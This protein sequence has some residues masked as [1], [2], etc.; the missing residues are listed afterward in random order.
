MD[1]P[2]IKIPLPFAANAAAP[3]RIA[4]PTTSQIGIVN[5]AASFNDGFPPL[6]FVSMSSG[7]VGPFGRDFNGLMYQI[8]AGLQ[9]EQAGYAATFDA[10]FSAAIGGYPA[11]AVL[12]S[13]STA[14][15]FY[16]N[17]VNSNTV[18]P[19]GA[20]T[21][22][23]VL[24]MATAFPISVPNGGTGETI[25]SPGEILLGNGI[26]PV[27]STPYLT[28][29]RGGT[30]ALSFNA[31]E[32]LIGNGV[33]AVNS[34]PVLNV[35]RGGTGNN[36]LTQ[37][38]VLAGSG[39]SGVAQIGVSASVG[40]PLCSNGASAHSSFQL[41]NLT[42]SVTGK[43]NLSNSPNS[44]LVV[45]TAAPGMYT[46]AVP[47][48]T[49]WI[50]GMCIGGGGGGAGGN[51][52]HS[53]GGGGAGGIQG[54][55]TMGWFAVMPGDLIN[56]TVGAGGTAGLGGSV[57]STN[58]GNGSTSSIGAVMSATGGAG[59]RSTGG[60]HD[61]GQ[62]GLGSFTLGIYNGYGGYGTDGNGP[63]D[64]A[65]SGGISFFGGGTR[66][67]DTPISGTGAPG[68]GGGGGYSL[69]S[70]SPGFPGTVL[71]WG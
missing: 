41:L 39:T 28:V 16:L 59:G 44:T 50:C 10:A 31:G 12:H 57:G 33:A 2:P 1:T 17:L 20:G 27:L 38:S 56:Y 26:N 61:G 51:G 60:N 32:I 36:A 48:N 19:D 24:W 40:Y 43:L 29:P 3:Y 67:L 22:W 53:G 49:Y 4:V 52:T 37:Y 55:P 30:G 62:G 69:A 25:L 58:G 66:G 21:N 11:G 63:S 64:V 47:V 54:G 34:T 18:D 8:T 6:N 46:F 5:G 13:V 71:I 65:G 15:K 70:A 68:A 14:N 45:G 23:M 9:Y 7:G 42:N 35:A